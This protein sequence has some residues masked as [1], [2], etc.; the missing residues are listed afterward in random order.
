MAKEKW[1]W[2]NKAER[3][4][5]VIEDMLDR[6]Y[7]SHY[8]AKRKKKGVQDEVEALVQNRNLE[9]IL[10]R[11]FVEARKVGRYVWIYVCKQ[12]RMAEAFH[13]LGSWE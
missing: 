12:I 6:E 8:L 2:L 1:G 10:C 7:G 5:E 9:E 13:A 4:E 11:E 3:D